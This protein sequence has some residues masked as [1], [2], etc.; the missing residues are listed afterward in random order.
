MG[1]VRAKHLGG[2]IDVDG[3]NRFWP[4]ASPLRLVTFFLKVLLI[5]ALLGSA[6]LHPNYGGSATAHPVLTRIESSKVESIYIP[7]SS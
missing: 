6:A 5:P 3:S 7:E 1:A 4:D 2:E